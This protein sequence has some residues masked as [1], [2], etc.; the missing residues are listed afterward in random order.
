LDVIGPDGELRSI[1]QGSLDFEGWV[2]SLGLLGIVTTVTLRVVPTYNVR[3]C[4]YT[5]LPWPVLLNDFDDVM[6][7]GYSVSA[8][9]TW[10]GDTVDQVWVKTTGAMEPSSLPSAVPARMTMHMIPG[11]SPESVTAQLGVEGPWQDRLPHFRMAF[12]PSSGAELQTEYFV[13]RSRAGDALAHVRR[14]APHFAPLLQVGEIRTVAGDRL[15]LS[16]A[17]GQDVV[18]LH[19]TWRR[20]W[21]QV[22]EILPLLEEA[23]LPLGG[24][25]HWGKCFVASRDELTAQYPRFGDFTA[26]RRRVDPVGKFTNA[27]SQRNLGAT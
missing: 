19:F 23:L 8:F 17:Y 2:V 16:G 5:G 18:A 12:T 14:L 13:P 24:R 3:Q 27:F 20:A 7:C 9:T 15:W 21:K 10:T 6:A 1:R 11:Q 22:H 26:L 4:V 25:P